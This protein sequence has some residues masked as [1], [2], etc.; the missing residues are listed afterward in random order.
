MSNSIIDSFK[1]LNVSEIET[2][3]DH[4]TVFEVS[5]QYLSKIKNFNDPKAFQNCLV[6]LINLERYHK[7]YE[8]IGKN[9][10]EETVHQVVLEIAYVYYKLGKSEQLVNLSKSTQIDNDIIKRGLNHI[11]AQDYYKNGDYAKALSL[12]YE[13]IDSNKFDNESDLMINE[14]SVISQLNFTGKLAS[15]SKFQNA[16]D[17]NY[18]LLFNDSLIELSKNNLSEAE[19]IL[20]KA[21]KLCLE[22]NSASREED[23]LIEL[24]PIKL[25]L[26]YI[27]QL[28]EQDEY[29]LQIL[30]ELNTD[31]VNDSMIKLI[32]KN[33]FYSLK[34]TDNPNLIE[35]DVA[36]QQNLHKLYHKLTKIQYQL[37]VKNLLLLKFT[38]N[39]LGA[40]YFTS[41]KIEK[42]LKDFEGDFTL[43]VYR[44]LLKLDITFQNLSHPAEHRST[45]RKL[46]KFVNKNFA[47]NNDIIVA[48]LILTFLCDKL[49]S[50]EQSIDIL[51]RL[52]ELDFENE[53]LLPGLISVLIKVYE[54]SNST[55]KLSTLLEKLASKLSSSS[56]NLFVDP[57]Y[58]S[59]AKA[60]AIKLY[61]QNDSESVDLF[62]SLNKQVNSDKLITAVLNG[63]SQDL[64]SIDKLV[65]N[66]PVEKLLSTP[67]EDL[68]NVKPTVVVR[69]KPVNI[70]V[71]KRNG[72][73][74]FSPGKVLKP[75]T[76]LQ[77]DDERWLPMKLRSYYKP[78]KKD[79]KKISSHQGVV[80]TPQAAPVSASTSSN[81]S[82]N[83]KKKKSKK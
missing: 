50:Y 73:R 69:Q 11:L 2:A 4:E 15:S 20:H 79:K 6:S 40:S 17:S 51:E 45:V 58:F 43:L 46:Y 65:S 36:Y 48:A 38:S 64:I 19:A 34:Y 35:R 81:V 3:S 16:N 26:V 62:A 29:A 37:I 61:N 57:G 28:Q 54:K 66:S 32:I 42:Y 44:L 56:A 83:K 10:D 60:I 75:K 74:K 14:K 30:K 41:K 8:L 68:I 63:S 47:Y 49:E 18:D 12:Y 55:K 13:L 78:S 77:L 7:A 76:E 27:Y 21:E 53:R 25:A 59:F 23:L 52:V 33:N 1:R 72:K 5:Y 9:K 24:A 80:E 22:Q 82:K 31:L 70:Q 67:I 39:T 71:K